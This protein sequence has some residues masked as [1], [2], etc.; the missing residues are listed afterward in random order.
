MICFRRKFLRKM[1]PILSSFYG[2]GLFLSS[3]TLC[4]TSSFLTPSVL[5]VVL[6][7][8]LETLLRGSSCHLD[9]NVGVPHLVGSQCIPTHSPASSTTSKLS[10]VARTWS[11]PPPCCFTDC[12]LLKAALVFMRLGI[13]HTISPTDLLHSSPLPHFKTFQYF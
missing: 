2:C 6:F 8:G 7:T 1:W 12:K 11:G 13:S 5:F 9:W 4:N 10:G 3:L